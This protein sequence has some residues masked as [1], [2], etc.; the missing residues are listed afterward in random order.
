MKNTFN[1][2]YN[3]LAA[4]QTNYLQAHLNEKINCLLAMKQVVLPT[5]KRLIEY[6]NL[7]LFMVAHPQ[8]SNMYELCQSELSRVTRHLKRFGNT[9]KQKFENTGLPF[10]KINTSFSYEILNW[11]QTQPVKLICDPKE[12]NEEE[13][14][15]ILKLSLP[16]IEKEYTA[17]HDSSS[18]L[19][20]T[21]QINSRNALPF[22]L[23][24]FA[25]LN[26]KPLIRDYLMEKLNIYTQIDPSNNGSWNKLYNRLPV[27]N[28]YYQTDLIKKWDY[29]SILN[30]SLNAPIDLSPA[31]RN[32]IEKTAKLK[33]ILLLRETEPVSY[34]DPKSI[35]YYELD[36]G[37]SIALFTMTA[38]RQLPVESYVGYT[39]YKNG[40]P[41]AYGGAWI[42]GSRALFGINI[43]DWF[44]GGESGFMMAQLLRTFRQVF[45]I[46]YFEVEPYQYGL[47]NPEGIASGAFWF[48]YRFGFRPIEKNINRLAQTEFNKMQKTK[49]YRSSA[50]TLLKFTTSN[51][52]LNLED[53]QPLAMWQIRNKVSR[54]IHKEFQGNRKLAE[55]KCIEKFNSRL[56]L[57]KTYPEVLQKPFI[58]FALICEAFELKEIAALQLV[59]QLIQT[60]SED[61]YE[62]QI[63]LHKFL[64]YLKK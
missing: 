29:T 4:L 38:Y 36:R 1:R 14:I 8:Q 27:E 22:L 54:M 53:H 18:E 6:S 37:I 47:N 61:V 9:A 31:F 26:E 49:S 7:L 34:M 44:R 12:W 20:D 43:F 35:R 25:A 51:I 48:Y 56:H 62:Y 42:M 39:L 45:S 17:I 55:L 57:N 58:D 5:D 28:L 59:D 10:M 30:S 23:G 33:L 32:E 24:E 16:D 41:A 64:H 46:N 60:K 2:I 3:Q 63:L 15:N 11:L 13:W 50:K 52:S 40:Y 21:L 19:L